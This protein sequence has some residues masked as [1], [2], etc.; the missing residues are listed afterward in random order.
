MRITNWPTMCFFSPSQ[1]EQKMCI[2]SWPSQTDHYKLTKDAHHKLTITNWPKMC[3]FR[4]VTNWTKNW[5]SQTDH[6]K[7]QT[8]HYKLIKNVHHK[9]TITNWPKVCITKIDQKY[10]SQTDHHKLT[11]SNWPLQTD[12][13]MCI[14]NWPSQIDH[15]KLTKNDLFQSITNWPKMCI[16]NQLTDGP[17]QAP[18]HTSLWTSSYTLT[19][20]VRSFLKHKRPD[21]HV[22]NWLTGPS[23]RQQ[24]TSGHP[25]IPWR[26]ASGPSWIINVQ[27]RTF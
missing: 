25:P 6:H 13:K 12:Q 3:N 9:L 16:L 17:P 27:T 4:S 24:H 2:T 26:S 10:A 19:Q 20:C 22:L 1:T 15:Y 11:I 18:L 21:M 5:P 7:P 8:D 14:T 23:H